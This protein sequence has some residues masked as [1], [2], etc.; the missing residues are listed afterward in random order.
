MTAKEYLQQA[1]HLDDRI[2]STIEQIRSLNDLATKCTS[3]ITGMPHSPSKSTSKM[4]DVIVKLVD[5]KEELSLELDTMVDLKKELFSTIKQVENAEHQ[6]LLEK[7][8]LCF[9]TWEKIA[10]D[11]NYSMQHI[12][13][14]HS[15]ALQEIRVP[16]EVE[17]KSDRM[18]V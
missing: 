12:H 8:Y 15:L 7:R 18:R 17:S 3:V 6:I 11:L 14:L 16:D 4:E 10:V 5:L 2:N 13:R 1:R 9:M